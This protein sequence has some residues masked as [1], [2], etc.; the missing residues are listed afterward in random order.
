MGIHNIQ[1]WKNSQSDLEAINRGYCACERGDRR[2]VRI[3]KSD[4]KRIT[5]DGAWY[6][7]RGDITI[8]TLSALN[9]LTEGANPSGIVL[10][11]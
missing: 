7:G 6:E 9:T 2:R 11:F 4:E 3:F 1:C 5:P 10:W 8:N